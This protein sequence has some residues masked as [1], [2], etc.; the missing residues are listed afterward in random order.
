MAA[1]DNDREIAVVDGSNVAWEERG[2]ADVPRMSNLVSMRRALE[3]RGFD[4]IIVVD[5]TLQHEVDDPD[6]LEALLDDDTIRQAPAEADADEF[7]L[8]IADEHDA[9]VV[10]NDRFEPYRNRFPWIED[11]RLPYMIVRGD[12]FLSPDD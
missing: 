1:P 3:D 5:A 9:V 7:I 12:V 11:R 10:S 6:Q 4:P 8:A 2:D